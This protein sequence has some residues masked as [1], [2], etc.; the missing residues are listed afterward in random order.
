MRDLVPLLTLTGALLCAQAALPAL[1]G[2][3]GMV[4][5]VTGTVTVKRGRDTLKAAPGLVVLTEDQILTGDKS[6]VGITLRD[7]TLLSAGPNA[8][9]SLDRFQF[10]TQTD[11]GELAM[12]VKRGALSVVSGKLAKTSPDSV[13][14]RTPGTTLGVRGTEFIIDVPDRGG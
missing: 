5:Q 11:K 8:T 9:L 13:H 7:N 4:K 1:A 10:D 6:A 3:A 14:F 12:S 2:E